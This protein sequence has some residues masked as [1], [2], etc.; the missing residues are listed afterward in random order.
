MKKT[1]TV[2]NQEFIY[3]RIF[4]K[5]NA[6]KSQYLGLHQDALAISLKAKPIDGKAN[7]ALTEFLSDFLDIPKSHIEI[8]KGDHSRIKIIKIRYSLAIENCLKNL[9]EEKD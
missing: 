1:Y 3:L 8:E 2:L 9:E 4:A 6:K 7:Q 5:P